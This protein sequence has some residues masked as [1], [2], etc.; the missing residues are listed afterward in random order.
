MPDIILSAD[1]KAQILYATL[2]S[3]LRTI[4]YAGHCSKHFSELSHLILNIKNSKKHPHFTQETSGTE[5][6][7]NLSKIFPQVESTYKPRNSDLS[8]CYQPLL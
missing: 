6:L 4:L 7:R 8:L 5:R 3:I 2:H 1:N